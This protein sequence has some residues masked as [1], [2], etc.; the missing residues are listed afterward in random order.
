MRNALIRIKEWLYATVEK[1]SKLEDI[2]IETVQNEI[3]WEEFL[4]GMEHLWGVGQ[5]QAAM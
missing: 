2:T 5:L 1:V 3:Q 4:T